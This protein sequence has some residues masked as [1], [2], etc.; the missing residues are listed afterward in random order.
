MRT[1]LYKP[2][3]MGGSVLENVDEAYLFP[4]Y[5]NGSF[6]ILVN[7]DGGYSVQAKGTSGGVT[8]SKLD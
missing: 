2:M 8:V 7:P 3:Y 5:T 4:G 6:S 1:I